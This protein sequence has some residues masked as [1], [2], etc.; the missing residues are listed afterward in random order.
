MQN[1]ILKIGLST[2]AVI[3]V[4][5]GAPSPASACGLFPYVGQIC[6]MAGRTCPQPYVTAAGQ[7]LPIA[8]YTALYGVIGT[9]YGS[10]GPSNFL[11]P[12]LQGRVPVGVGQGPGQPPYTLGET[13]GATTVTLSAG[14]MGAHNHIVANVPVS[15]TVANPIKGVQASPNA[16]S[17][18]LGTPG[19]AI[20]KVNPTATVQMS[21]TATTFSGSTSGVTGSTGSGAAE[22]NLPPLLTINYCIAVTGSSPQHP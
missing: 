8:N 22:D 6:M 17:G 1:Q 10:D 11:L 5:A 12:N 2:A 20:Y 14:Q 3:A 15:N 18:F 21:S 19:N 13:G 9:V 16:S 4:T 7:S